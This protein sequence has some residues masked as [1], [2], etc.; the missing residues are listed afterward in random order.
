MAVGDP[1][2]NLF[3]FAGSSNKF[4]NEFRK[5][6]AIQEQPERCLFANYRSLPA[7]VDFTNAFID[8]AIP[9]NQINQ[10]GEKIYA[11]RNDGK[12]EIL[13]GEYSHLY[14]ASQWIAQKIRDLIV[15]KGVKLTEIAVL[16]H[17]WNDLKFVQHF[18]QEF[19]IPYQFYDNSDN[20]QPANS[21]IG[22]KVLQHLRQDPSLKI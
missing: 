13:W 6:W 3:E 9:N 19:D 8:Q 16:A 17:R 2:Q 10:T 7:I 5:D 12:G 1:N 22:Q 20:L 11:H 4:I 18:L 14:Y 15:N 21:L